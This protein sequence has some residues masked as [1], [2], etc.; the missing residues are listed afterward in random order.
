MFR[1][2][3]VSLAGRGEYTEFHEFHVIKPQHSTSIL[4]PILLVVLFLLVCGSIVSYYYRHKIRT[5]FQRLNDRNSLLRNME[6]NEFFD[7]PL[8]HENFNR[9]SDIEELEE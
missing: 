7:V 3:A 2:M 6:M 4:A 1:V 8:D 5:L 9:L